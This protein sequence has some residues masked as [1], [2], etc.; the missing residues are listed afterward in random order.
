MNWYKIAEYEKFRERIDNI[1]RNAERPFAS[2]FPNGDR[3]YIP[4]QI[5]NNENIEI[6]QYVKKEL[7]SQGYQLDVE[8]YIQ[9]YCFKDGIK[10][11]IGKII[12]KLYMIEKK[13]L[14]TA[15][16]TG[17]KYSVEQ[18]LRDIQRYYEELMQEFVNSPIR[19]AKKSNTFYVVISQNPHDVASMS[20]DRQ[21]TSCMEL[22][23]GAHHDDVYK[24]V[25]A[26]SLVAYLVREDDKNIED[27]LA[28]I[29]IKRFVNKDRES[30]AVAE[31]SVYGQ[32]VAG[33]AETVKQ[34]LISKQGDIKPGIYRRCGGQW[35][36]TFSDSFFTPPTTKE[37]WMKWFRRQ[38]EN[39]KST[40]Y[41][42]TLSDQFKQFLDYN[43]ISYYDS[44]NFFSEEEAERW[45]N[46]HDFFNYTDSFLEY[47]S[48]P[49]GFEKDDDDDEYEEKP[50]EIK[51]RTVDNSGS[52]HMLAI[53]EIVGAEKG[54][55]PIEIIK[56]IKEL[57]ASNRLMMNETFN[58]LIKKYPEIFSKEELVDYFDKFGLTQLNQI[59]N[60]DIKKEILPILMQNA[61]DYLDRI[62]KNPQEL[63]S[64]DKNIENDFLRAQVNFSDRVTNVFNNKIDE[65]LGENIIRKLEAFVNRIDLSIQNKEF[66]EN[67]ELEMSRMLSDVA[68]IFF[69]KNADTPSAQRTYATI[70]KYWGNPRQH[71]PFSNQKYSPIN[72]FTVGSGLARLGNNG[73]QFLP[74]L[75]QKLEEEQLRNE[76]LKKDKPDNTWYNQLNEE[77]KFSDNI[78]ETLLYIIDSIESGKGKSSKYSFRR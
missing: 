62:T 49:D 65:R 56:E 64:A 68:H 39:A 38:D 15:F 3:V 78:V 75:K 34:W 63:F 22:G 53:K 9:G 66:G 76:T 21:W 6:D 71:T 52:M 13:K 43:D 67:T 18:D 59:E 42:V 8:N 7:E 27:P 36:D 51:T 57:F 41:T 50:Y 11:K 14:E 58:T 46:S 5:S 70:L 74:F 37:G 31:S 26:G 35:S 2:W 45:I 61:E 12:N 40:Y 69:M 25:Q 17:E 48:E 23:V 47:Q 24:E 29:A 44:P 19:A 72:V 4:L 20:T 10:Y 77:I 32:E 54:E 33:F 60:D 1:S 28:R 30:V 55:Y 16:Q 73:R